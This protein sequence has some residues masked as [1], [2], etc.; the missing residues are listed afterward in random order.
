MPWSAAGREAGIPSE[1]FEVDATLALG[2][3]VRR[4]Q[5]ELAGTP[6]LWLLIFIVYSYLA[7][8]ALVVCLA[9]ARP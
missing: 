1:E 7:L 8:F 3:R 2:G 5:R 9:A 4:F 6:H